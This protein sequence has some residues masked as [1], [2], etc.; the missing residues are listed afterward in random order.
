MNRIGL[1]RVVLNGRGE[2]RRG[3]ERRDRKRTMGGCG[4]NFFIR[5]KCRFWWCKDFDVLYLIFFVCVF[6]SREKFLG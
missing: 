5:R 4:S 6:F 1:C 3:E 2:E